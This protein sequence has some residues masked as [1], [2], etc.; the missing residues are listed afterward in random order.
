MDFSIIF[1]SV[2]FLCEVRLT[3]ENHSS[4][5]SSAIA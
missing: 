5:L 2:H 1:H 3:L 4:L